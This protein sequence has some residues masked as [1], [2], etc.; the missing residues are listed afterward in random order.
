VS[1]EGAA[2]LMGTKYEGYTKKWPV[3]GARLMALVARVGEDG[4]PWVLPPGRPIRVPAS[5]RIF[6][7]PNDAPP[8]DDNGGELTVTLRRVATSP[9]D[10]RAAVGV[11]LGHPWTDTGIDVRPDDGLTFISSGPE[12]MRARVGEGA[13]WDVEYE[14]KAA[15]AG[16]LFLGPAASDQHGEL[17]VTVLITRP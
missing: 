5:G 3:A 16:R 10:A 4:V 9:A 15:S 17:K 1:A 6:L 12:K 11:P 7:G 2:R 13:P 14:H 8:G